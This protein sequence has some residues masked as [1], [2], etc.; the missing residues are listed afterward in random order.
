MV[1]IFKVILANAKATSA[2]IKDN[3]IENNTTNGREKLSYNTTITIYTKR[4]AAIRETNKV[5][6][7]SS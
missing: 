3:G 4:I 6:N 7:P 1:N 2:P 5:P